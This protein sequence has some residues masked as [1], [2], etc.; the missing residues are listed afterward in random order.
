MTLSDLDP[1]V[2]ALLVTAGVSL[3]TWLY[4]KASGEKQETF[5]GLVDD[6]ADQALHQL[7]VTADTSVDE[8]RTMLTGYIRRGLVGMSIKRNAAIDVL[9]GVAV[10]AA[11]LKALDFVRDAY[12][13]RTAKQSEAMLRATL[14][15]LV[16]V[17]E[18]GIEV[19]RAPLVPREGLIVVEP[20][21]DEA[22]HP[23]FPK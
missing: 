9:V 11:V 16:E 18:R 10:E 2:A 15:G 21:G 20:T 12:I 14:P 19:G 3:A 1:N 22:Y 4:R 5:S 13:A 23:A 6:L 7:V 17:A 8:I